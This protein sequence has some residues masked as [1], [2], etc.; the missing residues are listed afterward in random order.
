MRPASYQEGNVLDIH[1]GQLF[2]NSSSIE[3]DFYTL[4]WCEKSAFNHD[5]TEPEA[6]G[7][8]M[9]DMEI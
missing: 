3:F 7:L 9:R 2:S 8:S 6:E 5:K 1:V 4:N